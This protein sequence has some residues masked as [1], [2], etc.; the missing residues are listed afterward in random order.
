M[1]KGNYITSSMMM[2]MAIAVDVKSITETI[3]AELTDCNAEASVGTGAT[4]RYEGKEEM[5]PEN[6]PLTSVQ[7][8]T[9]TTGLA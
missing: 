8:S 3:L 2:A 5:V 7:E 1:W 4:I 9:S 6:V